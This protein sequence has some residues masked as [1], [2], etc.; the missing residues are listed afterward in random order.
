MRPI[1]SFSISTAENGWVIRRIDS[2]SQGAHGDFVFQNIGEACAFL[3]DN[4]VII[5][6]IRESWE[7]GHAKHS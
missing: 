4:L 7:K 3:A 1:V 5:A 6:D 2:Y